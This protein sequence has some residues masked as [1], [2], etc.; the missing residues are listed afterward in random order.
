MKQRRA[1]AF[2]FATVLV[3]LP[4]G[5]VMNSAGCSDNKM[6]DVLGD[7][8]KPDTGAGKMDTGPDVIAFDGGPCDLLPLGGYVT[9][10]AMTGTAPAAMG[11][12]IVDGL[13]VLTAAQLY[14]TGT[15]TT[16]A[17]SLVI[18]NG[19]LH[20]SKLIKGET[21]Y[22][23]LVADYV[24]DP[25]AGPT[26]ISVSFHDCDDGGVKEASTATQVFGFT[27]TPTTFTLSGMVGGGT[28]VNLFT[29]Q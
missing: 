2:G 16:F 15:S 9:Q 4:Y 22:E 28:I 21:K 10:K 11:G 3:L 27:A 23:N 13:Y 26:Q 25:D 29:K 12:T 14:G 20:F 17:Q 5:L 18:Q 6:P 24:V 1:C 8:P 19:T 7:P